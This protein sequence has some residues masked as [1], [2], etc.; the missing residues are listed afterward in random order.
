M[1]FLLASQ[2]FILQHALFVGH[3]VRVALALPLLFCFQTAQVVEK[4]MTRMRL[5]TLL[6]VIFATCL[7]IMIIVQV[8]VENLQIWTA[9]LI[10]NL[11]A[12]GLAICIMVTF[13]TL[14]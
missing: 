8:L 7:T 10:W 11:S 5:V 12:L 4:R 6:E 9:W 2:C 3:Y 14:K 13:H 1:L